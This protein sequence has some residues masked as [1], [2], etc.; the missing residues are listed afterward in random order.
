MY[1]IS[2]KKTSDGYDV[3]RD[4]KLIASPKN[5]RELELLLNFHGIHEGFCRDFI[6]GLKETGSAV[7]EMPVI[8]FR[9]VS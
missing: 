2:A 3:F 8:N 9:Q 4:G 6:R 5:E 1:T 7:E